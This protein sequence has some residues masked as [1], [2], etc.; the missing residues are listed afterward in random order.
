MSVAA[1]RNDG[2]W[3]KKEILYSVADQH[4]VISFKTEAEEDHETAT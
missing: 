2:V 1:L 4:R 3:I